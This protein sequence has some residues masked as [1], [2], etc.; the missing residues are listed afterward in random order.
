MNHDFE[1]RV[2]DVKS[3]AHGHWTPIL[4]A[5]GVDEEHS[6]AARTILVHRRLRRH[7]S[8]P[9][10]RQVRRRQ[11]PLPLLRCRWRPEAR[12]R[13]AGARSSANCSTDIERQL[14]SVR[15]A[16]IA[17]PGRPVAGADEASV[18]A[19]S[20]TRP[21]PSPSGDEV[22]RYL[23]NRGL[24]LSPTRARCAFIRRWATTR[25]SPA[26]SG[27]RRSPSY[28][29]MLASCRAP[30]D[31]PSPCTAPTCRDGRKALGDA[32]QA[33]CCRPA[34]TARPC[35]LVRG[36]A[37]NSRVAEGIETA[38]AV[39]L[40]TGKPV[41]AALNCGNLEKLWIPDPVARVCIYADNDADAEFDGQASAYAL[42]HRLRDA[43]LG[44]QSDRIARPARSRCSSPDRTAPTGPTSGSPASP[45]TRR[46]A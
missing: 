46:A 21:G 20:G 28:P 11:L 38:L 40:S 44:A 32:V 35:R 22:D 29:A 19:A 4:E 16:A 7:R 25:S 31:M 42:A 15:P 13:R 45:T 30:T 2:R 27:R 9:V 5:L 41:W 8:L 43:K 26:S 17:R 37:T 14:G 3:R 33:R 24:Q 1:A 10:H 18:P 39:H 6:Q 23:R 36:H 12:A 34:S